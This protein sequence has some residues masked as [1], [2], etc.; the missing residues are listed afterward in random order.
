MKL[1]LLPN[2]M[3]LLLSPIIFQRLPHSSHNV[4]IPYGIDNQLYPLVI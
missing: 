2:T 3:G 4:F 1:D